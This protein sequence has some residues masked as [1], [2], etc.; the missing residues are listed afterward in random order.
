[1]VL[2]IPGYPEVYT[3]QDS[4]IPYQTTLGGI[5]GSIG[6]V[7]SVLLGRNANSYP[8]GNRELFYHDISKSLQQYNEGNI[9]Q[10]VSEFDG[11]LKYSNLYFHPKHFDILYEYADLLSDLDSDNRE[12]AVEETYGQ[13][14]E[15]IL[16]AHIVLTNSDETQNIHSKLNGLKNYSTES[17]GS[18]LLKVLSDAISPIKTERTGRVVFLIILGAISA[19]VGIIFGPT[20]V[21]V[22]L[23]LVTI[24][25][26]LSS[27]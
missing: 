10:F 16:T 25:S 20:W 23:S 4:I 22:I 17:Q 27:E 8:I 3:W 1:L 11:A 26:T 6:F 13:V 19:G 9:D 14:V 24:Y 7:G 21:I 12:K 2:T 15:P 18:I 5:I